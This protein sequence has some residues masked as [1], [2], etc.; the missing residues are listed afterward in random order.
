MSYDFKEVSV[1]DL[2][3]RPLFAVPMYAAF[4][5]NVFDLFVSGSRSNLVLLHLV[6]VL[7]DVMHLLVMLGDTV[8]YRKIFSVCLIVY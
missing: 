3:Q 4:R 7:T 8:F 1:L 6:D 2:A 5:S